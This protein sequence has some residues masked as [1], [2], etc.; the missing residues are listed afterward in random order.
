MTKVLIR[1]RDFALLGWFVLC[2]TLSIAAVHSPPPGGRPPKTAEDLYAQLRSI[3]LDKSRVYVIREA[4]LDRAELHITFESGTIA[5]TQ[6][7]YGRITGAFF[8]G[9]G[10]VLLRPPNATERASMDLFTGMAILEEQFGNG[11]FRFNDDVYGEL[12]PALRPASNAEEFISNWGETAQRLAEFDALRLLISFSQ[13]LPVTGG[14]TSPPLIGENRSEPDRLLHARL[15]GQTLGN[16]DLYFDTTIQES[17]WAGQSR[18]T[19]GGTYYD[20]WTSFDSRRGPRSVNYEPKQ[21]HVT[22][23]RFKIRADVKPPTD[24]NGDARLQLEVGRGGQRTLLFELSRFLQLKSV[25]LNGHGVEF[26][27]N[28]ALEGTQLQRRGND[29]VAVVFPA[30]LT[31]GE[32]LELHFVYAGE[33]LSEAGSGLLYVG[34]RGTWYPNRG[35][36][37][38]NFDLEFRYPPG[39]TLLATGKRTA[40]ATPS[41]PATPSGAAGEASGQQVGRWVSE[42]PIPLAGFNLGKYTRAVARVGEVLVESYATSGVE[43]T[44]PKPT[45]TEVVTVPDVHHPMIQGPPVAVTPL[46]PSPARNAQPVADQSARAIEFFAR[47]FGPFPYSS[48]ELTQMPGPMSEGWPG[49][50]FLS[51]YSFLTPA[52]RKMLHMDR[53]DALLSAQVLTHET[54]HQWWGDLVSW[55]SYRDQ[56][57]MEALANYCTMMVVQSEN[58][59]EFRDLMEKFRHDLLEK[60]KEGQILRDAGPVTLGTRL[61]SSHFPNGYEAISYGRGTWLFHMLREMM[62]DADSKS[63]GRPIRSGQPDE[64]FIRSLL[65]LRE[66][67]QGKVITTRELLRVFEEDLSPKLRY[68]NRKSLDWFLNGWI[69]GTAMPVLEL[70]GVKYIPRE[71]STTV[72]GTLR[73]KGAPSDLVTPVPIYASVGGKTTVLLGRVFADGAETNFRLNAPSGTR[74]I[75]LDPYQTLLTAAR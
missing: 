8:A 60:N 16:F 39:W 9:E 46:P 40:V 51:S 42:R 65:K 29:L 22:I 25:D 31:A 44:F 73:Q 10:E 48:L 49:L 3:G 33:V 13:F 11:Y 2:G 30:P 23:T 35:L 24:L 34:A 68:E 58:P 53:L 43:R 28:Q 32:K 36:A 52:E 74:R 1:V 20:V 62:R 26:I 63:E 75:V 7:I 41:E 64:P 37:M 5:F 54:A 67:Y 6:D 50:V 47:R 56:W 66:R 57:M 12:Q 69:N 21:D 38:S 72:T 15:Q 45:T 17:V 70:E 59:T 19:E 71:N 27:H 14:G 4:S 61:S 55:R 18:T